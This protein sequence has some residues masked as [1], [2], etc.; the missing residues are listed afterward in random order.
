MNFVLYFLTA[1]ILGAIPFAY[2]LPRLVKNI[3]IRTVGSKNPGATNVRR[4]LGWPL[5]LVVLLLDAGKGML[6]LF[7]IDYF[8]PELNVKSRIDYQLIAGLAAV[9]G[10][11]YSPF[12]FFKGGKG[13]ATSLGVFLILA[14]YPSLLSILTFLLS[15]KLCKIVSISTMLAAFF[16]PTFYILVSYL[17]LM[18]YSQNLLITLLALFVLIVVRHRSNIYRIIQGTEFKVEY[19]KIDSPHSNHSGENS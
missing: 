3:D 10:H 17:G 7:L 16:M 19:K 12:L 5:G 14:P 18:A 9:L 11:S 15:L 2:L 1:F 4:V 13:V 8:I 6:A